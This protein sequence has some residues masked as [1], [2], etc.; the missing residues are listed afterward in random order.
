MIPRAF[1]G[2]PARS[3]VAAGTIAGKVLSVSQQRMSVVQWRDY[4]LLRLVYALARPL[5][6]RLLQQVGRRLGWF[7]WHLAPYRRGVVLDNLRGAFG[8]ERDEAG[9]RRLGKAFYMQLGT[10]LLEFCGTWR[11]TPRQIE[12]LID[13]DGAEHLEAALSAERGALLVSGH[14]GN[15]ELMA[16]WLATAGRPVRFLVKTQAN[17]RV[18]RLQNELRERAG[19]G[20]IRTQTATREM[21]R[22]LRE[23]GVIGLLGDQH[24]GSGGLFMEFLGRQ[25]S[26]FR[27]TAQLARRLRCPVLAGFLVRKPDGRH[28][29]EIVPPLFPDPSW[30]ENEAVER[31]TRWH[32]GC[33]EDVVRRHPDHYFWIH[34]RWKAA[35]VHDRVP[36]AGA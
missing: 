26:V 23:G 19:V 3:A 7:C 14:F 12:D 20:V 18:D 31:I 10:T 34:R 15:W 16:A 28:R 9:I 13:V 27:G 2:G 6:F 35:P 30:S 22:T 5:P 4:F 24:A 29:L 21:V 17:P 11:L 8:R 32:T 1:H 36:E 25:A 33:L